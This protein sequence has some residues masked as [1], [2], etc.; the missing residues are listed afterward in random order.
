MSV[1]LWAYDDIKCDGMPCPG[2]CD[3]CSVKDEHMCYECRYFEETGIFSTGTYGRC[4]IDEEE[5]ETRNCIWK[6]CEDFE[7]KEDE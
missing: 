3:R 5:P 2:D 6:A 7:E 1:S 4:V